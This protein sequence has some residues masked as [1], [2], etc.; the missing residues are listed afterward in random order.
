[1]ESMFTI[2]HIRESD[3]EAVGKLWYN[4]SLHHQIFH[5]YYSVRSGTEW[6]LISHVRD[7]INRDCIGFVAEVNEKIVGFVTGYIV[8]RNPQLEV[9]R[10][11]KVDNIFVSESFRGHDI[12]TSLLEDLFSFFKSQKV[13]YIEISCD[14]QND[15]AMRLYKRLGFHEQKV[16]LIKELPV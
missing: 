13:K 5:K 8:R 10:I 14:V 3:S 11:G 12:G 16:M 4:L 15:D 6:Q 7:L 1:M 9:E 2:R